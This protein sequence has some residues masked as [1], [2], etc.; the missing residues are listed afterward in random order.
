MIT[1]IRQLRDIINGNTAP[2][3]PSPPLPLP[4]E[5]LPLR[6]RLTKSLY[7]PARR[8]IIARW[9]VGRVVGSA[10]G[11]LIVDFQGDLVRL[12]LAGNWERV[13]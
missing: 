8:M 4:A 9:V 6:I 3:Q 1:S 11:A 10:E 7:V 12:P 13:E 2:A 5:A